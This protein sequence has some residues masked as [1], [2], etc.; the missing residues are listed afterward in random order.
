M[1]FPGLLCFS[2]LLRRPIL[3]ISPC[4]AVALFRALLLVRVDISVAKSEIFSTVYGE[5]KKNKCAAVLQRCLFSL[6]LVGCGVLRSMTI[7]HAREVF[8]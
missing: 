8:V 5:K 4:G 6:Q 7:H 3:R 1:Q 2:Q